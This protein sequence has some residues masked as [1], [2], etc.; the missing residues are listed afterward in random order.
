MG[1]SNATILPGQNG[2]KEKMG[3]SGSEM[4]VKAGSEMRETTN[5]LDEDSGTER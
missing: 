4:Q 3:Q 2:E 1:R 5:K